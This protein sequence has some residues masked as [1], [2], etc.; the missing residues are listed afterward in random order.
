MEEKVQFKGQV[1]YQ[2]I[3]KASQPTLVLFKLKLLDHPL[4]PPLLIGQEITAIIAR[5]ALTFMLD[6]S[7]DDQIVIFGHYNQR[8]QLII[9]KY[10]IESKSKIKEL[11]HIHKYP[12]R[13]NT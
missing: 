11:N 13:K 4:N 5:K 10:L 2:K 8:K 1:T 12:K 7:K 6:V 9:E 3:I